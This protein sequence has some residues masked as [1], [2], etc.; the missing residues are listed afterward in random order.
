MAKANQRSAKAPAKRRVTK[1]T[2]QK[3]GEEK[4]STAKAGGKNALTGRRVVRALRRQQ[5]RV[6][7][8]EHLST[9]LVSSLT[10]G[11]G[12]T[13]KL[14]VAVGD[15]IERADDAVVEA[16]CVEF[17]ERAEKAKVELAEM[18][19]GDVNKLALAAEDEE[20]E[21]DETGLRCTVV[22][23]PKAQDKARR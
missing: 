6:A 23:N 22:D 8:L 5:H 9:Y 2:K 20:D 19:G 4:T 7:L 13:P 15:V 21:A 12:D 16:L 3:V 17:S 14:A 11:Y 10:E 18:L 1:A